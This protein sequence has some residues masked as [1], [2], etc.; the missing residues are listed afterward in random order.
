MRGVWPKIFPEVA[1]MLEVPAETAVATPEEV[2]VATEV[3]PEVQVTE[4][5]RFCVE[6]SLKVPI[7]RKASVEWMESVGVAGAS[8]METRVGGTEDTVSEAV[9][10]GLPK[11]AEM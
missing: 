9:P 1:V 5:V 10:T 6:P 3:V 7:A 8:A 2:M 11:D 4:E